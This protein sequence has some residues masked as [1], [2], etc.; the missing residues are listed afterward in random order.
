MR[1]MAPEAA[2]G[3]GADC[4][5]EGLHCAMGWVPGVDHSAGQAASLRLCNHL[6]HNVQSGALGSAGSQE[7][8]QT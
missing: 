2:Q 5:L 8:C 3:P 6:L 4:N 7:H 1:G